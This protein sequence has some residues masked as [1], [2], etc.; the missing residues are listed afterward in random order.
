[1][2]PKFLKSNKPA[3]IILLLLLTVLNVQAEF[4][5]K[6]DNFILISN[7]KDSTIVKYLTNILSEENSYFEFFFRHQL[8]QDISI[9][10]PDS[11]N[12][13]REMTQTYLPDWSGA[14]TIMP[15]G[16]IILKPGEY[17][18]PQ[19]SRETLL[20]ELVHIYLSDMQVAHKVPLWFNEGMA[21]HL[22]GKS[23]SWNESIMLGNT[24][25]SGNLITLKE[26][27]RLLS[28]GYIKAHTAYLEA[29]LAVQYM[30]E[31]YGEGIIAGII[32]SLKE[33]NSF[34]DALKHNIG[35]DMLEFEDGWYQY[36]KQRY[37]W[38]VLLQFENLLWIGL[39][40]IVIVGFFYI[41]V[42]NRRIIKNWE[43]DPSE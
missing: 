38:M 20:H 26:I 4:I 5:L 14:V 11:P 10:L 29:L 7:D 9:V 19:E 8:M 28:F 25:T 43:T 17:F 3:K 31:I 35:R 42:R 18:E 40:I 23:I 32:N 6:K 30:I 1:L 13:Y 21:M 22:S 16:K 37:S 2:Y 15:E 12:Q 36:L 24:I 39:V 34:N 41:K 33:G 27:D